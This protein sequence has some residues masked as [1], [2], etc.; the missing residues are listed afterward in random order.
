MAA[1]PEGLQYFRI[2]QDGPAAFVT[3][4]RPP[5]NA[6]S[7]DFMDGLDAVL[8]RLAADP[9]VRAVAFLSANPRIFL[10]GADLGAALGGV[11]A[12]GGSGGDEA[13]APADRLRRMVR[14]FQASLDRLEALPK[15]TVAAI[16][17]HALGG[18][19]EF[20]LACDF[21][22]MLA[23]QKATIG[24]T[25]TRLGLLPGA[26][27]TQR[28]PRVVGEGR[29]TDLI[30]RAR[31]LLAEEAVAIGLVHEAVP[32]DAFAARVREFTR[33]L[34]EAATLALGEAK[35]AIH[36]AYGDPVAGMAVE[37]DA[38]TRLA[39]TADA[40]EGISAFFSRRAPEFK[41]R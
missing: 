14:R 30:L 8:G 29:A 10:A 17:G 4:D 36:A 5:A 38:F 12:E 24:Q 26:G 7:P 20:A 11:P 19:C 25:E 32:P 16:G 23:D 3:M 41:G 34:A 22:V 9:E 6:L 40:M 21:R 13:E 39:F 2:E 15:P 35:R 33:E 31:R 18:G 1:E 27:G 37:A 28:L